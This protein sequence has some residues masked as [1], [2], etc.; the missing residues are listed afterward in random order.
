MKLL[1]FS[2]LFIE[3]SIYLS[4]SFLNVFLWFVFSHYYWNWM[5]EIDQH[6][7]KWKNHFFVLINFY[8]KIFFYFFKKNVYTLVFDSKF[9]LKNLEIFVLK[10]NLDYCHV[11]IVSNSSFVFFSNQ[12][13]F[14]FWFKKIIVVKSRD[15]CF[16]AE[17]PESH[18]RHCVWQ[19][20][21]AAGVEYCSC[22]TE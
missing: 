20:F 8:L 9:C 21:R 18:D 4:F 17:C 16:A 11:Q 13:Y 22:P 5:F 6:L 3:L 14:S 10:N 7:R 2:F 19:Q 1:F 15:A 12:N